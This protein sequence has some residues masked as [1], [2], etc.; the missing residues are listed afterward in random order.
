MSTFIVARG[1]ERW[2]SREFAANA[3]GSG[4]FVSEGASLS[5]WSCTV[6]ASKSPRADQ[7]RAYRFIGSWPTQFSAGSLR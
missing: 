5:W 4:R 6:F 1:T 3:T 2:I 7:W